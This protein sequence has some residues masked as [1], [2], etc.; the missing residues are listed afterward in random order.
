MLPGWPVAV[1]V[2][3]SFSTSLKLPVTSRP[4]GWSSSVSWSA[5]GVDTTGASLTGST[6][7]LR[8]KTALRALGSPLPSSTRTGTVR[9]P[10]KS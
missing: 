1:K 9:V 7:T 10:L 5:M 6:T 8:L 2:S 3:G 4:K